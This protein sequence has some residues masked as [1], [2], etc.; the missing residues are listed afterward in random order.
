ML[1]FAALAS[2]L[3]VLLSRTGFGLRVTMCG[4]NPLAALFAA[5][6]IGRLLLQVS[7]FA[8]ELIWGALLLFVVVI[9]VTDW[10]ALRRRWRG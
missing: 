5:I 7:H 10:A 6:D 4:A 8:R 3:H 9:N 1:L 2:G